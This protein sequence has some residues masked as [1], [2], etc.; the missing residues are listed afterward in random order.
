MFFF[1]LI[2]LLVFCHM[3]FSW[4]KVLQVD[5][6]DIYYVKH[7]EG[8]KKTIY[9]FILSFDNTFWDFFNS[10]LIKFFNHSK[11]KNNFDWLPKPQKIQ[12]IFNMSIIR[13]F[14]SHF[15]L[16]HKKLAKWSFCWKYSKKSY[17]NCNMDVIASK[18]IS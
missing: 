1:F 18:Q 17:L 4:N 15:E 11:K 7:M 8:K 13:L 3:H 16:Y 6:M 5:M 2:S 9:L 14:Y 12:M 10:H